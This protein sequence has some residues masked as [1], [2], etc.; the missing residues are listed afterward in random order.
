MDN[1]RIHHA[2]ETTE[3]VRGLLEVVGVDIRFL[4]VYRPEL[5]PCEL[6]FSYVNTFLRNHRDNGLMWEEA[7]DSFS[8][9]THGQME[10][11]YRHCIM[12]PLR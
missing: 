7:L 4:P 8:N 1:A 9:I 11:W 12:A 3:I 2:S 5:N 6:V 10:G